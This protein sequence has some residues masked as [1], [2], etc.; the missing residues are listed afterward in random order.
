MSALYR[1][2]AHLPRETGVSAIEVIL[3]AS[4][5]LV[6][7]SAFG[8]VVLTTGLTSSGQVQRTLSDA[9]ARSGSGLELRGPVIAFTDGEKASAI[10]MD[11]TLGIGG[12]G[13]DLEPAAPLGRTVVSYIDATNAIRELPYSVQWTVGDDDQTLEPGELAAILI[14]VTDV[15]PALTSGRAFRIEV[16]PPHGSYL[17]IRRTMP[18]GSL[19]DTI[20]NLQ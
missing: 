15:A 12:D 7:A 19:L 6:V 11:V 20:V 5:F 16:R 10:S 13:V 18:H 9:L 14:D 4:G 3:I 17:T 2:L 8:G 1:H